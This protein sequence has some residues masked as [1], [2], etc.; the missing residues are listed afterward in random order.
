MIDQS[1]GQ[2]AVQIAK[3][4]YED[5]LKPGARE[6]GKA[7]GTVGAAVNTA[8]APLRFVVWSFDQIELMI[9]GKLEERLKG[10]PKEKIV[11]PPSNVAVPVLEALRYTADLEPL[12]EMFVNLLAT[13]MNSDTSPKA[14]PSFAS[15]IKDL[16]PDEA[17]IIQHLSLEENHACIEF[18]RYEHTD[19][20]GYVV[21]HRHLTLLGHAA[22][23][24]D[25]HDVAQAIE[26]LI[27]NRILDD[28]K[29]L[30]MVD[31]GLYDRIEE[32][33][34]YEA[35]AEKFKKEGIRFYTQRYSVILTE[36]GRRFVEACVH[37]G[38]S[39]EPGSGAV[40]HHL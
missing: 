29:N 31:N 1:L 37:Q 30:Q 5:A 9:K 19:A 24:S 13:S 40:E 16:T 15:I 10:V 28:A 32:L 14:H 27:R 12:R 6:M 36:F 11:T 4:L 23:V 8:L 26:N 17:R 18:H 20:E 38:L 25:P 35:C 3:P 22:G 7:L 2:A 34:A 21:V 39:P 33:P